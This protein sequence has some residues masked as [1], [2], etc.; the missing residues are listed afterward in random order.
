MPG[1]LIIEVTETDHGFRATIPGLVK[2]TRRAV[3][4]HP[5]VFGAAIPAALRALGSSIVDIKEG[6]RQQGYE[7]NYGKVFS[8]LAGEEEIESRATQ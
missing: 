1:K 6:L 8:R 3:W 5:G 2:L 4:V 7:H